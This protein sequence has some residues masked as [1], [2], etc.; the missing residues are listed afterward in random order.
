MQE[1]EEPI[2]KAL[3]MVSLITVH[4]TLCYKLLNTVQGNF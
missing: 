3:E 4:N 2:V 1:K